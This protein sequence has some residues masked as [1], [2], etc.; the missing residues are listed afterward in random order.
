[1]RITIDEMIYTYL[2]LLMEAEQGTK[3]RI[4]VWS[5][6][7]RISMANP[8]QL[9]CQVKTA[10]MP[11]QEPRMAQS[12]R[13][14]QTHYPSAHPAIVSELR[15]CFQL[16]QTDRNSLLTFDHLACYYMDGV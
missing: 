10:Q 12:L 14:Y 5:V 16:I 15:T 7:F 6:V 3:S 11:P 1:M 8:S 4:V 9:V 13:I 2:I